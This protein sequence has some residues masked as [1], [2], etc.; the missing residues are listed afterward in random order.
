MACP[1]CEAPLARA[2]RVGEA[3]VL[4]HVVCGC[5]GVQL[6]QPPGEPPREP[7]TDGLAWPEVEI[8]ADRQMYRASALGK[9]GLTTVASF[10][11]RRNLASLAA[12]REAIGGV[13]DEEV[14]A[15][16][17]FAFTAILT[18]A[19]KRYQWSRKRPLNAANA[20]YYVAPVFY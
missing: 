16:L 5:S 11:S 1:R 14:A 20:N 4:D 9:H 12:L 6:E 17:Q 2:R 13:G 18:R 3:R 8:A 19:S 10:Y 15:K 7:D